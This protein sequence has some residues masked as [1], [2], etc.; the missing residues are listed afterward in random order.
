VYIDG[1]NLYFG[2]VEKGFRK[3][4]WLDVKRFARS[5]LSS[6]QH[7]AH[8]KYFT[9]RVSGPPDKQARQTAVIEANELSTDVKYL[10]GNY[11]QSTEQC[12]RCAVPF[13]C[14]S[15]GT[16]YTKVQEKKTDVN[17]ATELLCDAFRNEF[18]AAYIVS[19][20]MDL[21]P[22]I[23]AVKEF[24]PDKM[25]NIAFP[26]GRYTA[27]LKS[28][29]FTHIFVGETHLAASQLP[30]PVVKPDGYQIRKPVSWA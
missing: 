1:F 3:Y 13:R 22:A 18:D 10:F 26:P 17:I 8:T 30:D 24:L 9:S 5:L 28:A 6:G 29:A 27:G 12:N 4:L 23:K 15:C 2:M 21:F 11:K 25:V 19:A 7:L 16:V 14:P 20:D